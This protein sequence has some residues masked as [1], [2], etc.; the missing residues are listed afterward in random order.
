MVRMGI[1]EVF[2]LA[3]S[4]QVLGWAAQGGGGVTVPRG[5][6]GEGG[7]AWGHGSMVI[8]VVGLGDLGGFCH[9]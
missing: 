9:P 5:V 1:K 3:R 8:L 6:Q 2:L 4:I 7:R